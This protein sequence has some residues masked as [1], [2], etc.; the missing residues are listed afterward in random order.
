MSDISHEVSVG[1]Y[2][3]LSGKGYTCDECLHILS[4][5]PSLL[6]CW[7]LL[8][9][10]GPRAGAY[11][12]IDNAL[13]GRGSGHARIGSYRGL[14]IVKQQNIKFTTANTEVAYSNVI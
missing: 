2:C 3:Y 1:N 7:I 6:I 4:I 10:R 11:T 12:A 13:R 9:S 5:V 14:F 8:V